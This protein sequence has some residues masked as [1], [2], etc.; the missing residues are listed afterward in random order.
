MKTSDELPKTFTHTLV[1]DVVTAETRWR[2]GNVEVVRRD[3][4][5]AVFA[6]VEG[7]NW[8][9]RQGL[10]A[11]HSNHLS[12]NHHEVAALLD[13]TYAVNERGEI[14]PQPRFIPLSSAIRMV[15]RIISRIRP[16]YTMDF[17][18]VGWSLLKKSIEA[19]NRI[20]H[21]KS[22]NDFNVSDDEVKD[23][24]RAFAWFLAY[25]IEVMREQNAD[26]E[27]GVDETKSQTSVQK[28]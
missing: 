19:R 9:L 23:A 25:V 10:V 16:E 22:L 21:P 15:V 18:H 11:T 24:L 7:L 17:G 28:S 12:L 2:D 1:G 14:S 27:V 20:V 8:Q 26:L 4:I 5:R 13:E 3:L 6:A